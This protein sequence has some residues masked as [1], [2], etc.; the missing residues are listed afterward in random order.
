MKAVNIGSCNI[1]YVYAMEHFIQPG[2]TKDCIRIW[3]NSGMPAAQEIILRRASCMAFLREKPS[4]RHWNP[5]AGW[6]VWPLPGTAEM[7]R[8]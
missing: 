2:E 5:A 7:T 6:P 1:D 4:R 3:V 8:R